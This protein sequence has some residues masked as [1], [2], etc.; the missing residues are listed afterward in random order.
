MRRERRGNPGRILVGVVIHPTP[1]K[2]ARVG[3]RHVDDERSLG[4]VPGVRT[5]LAPAAASAAL[6][7]WTARAVNREIDASYAAVDDERRLVG[8]GCQT[9]RNEHCLCGVAQLV[10]QDRRTE[11][12]VFAGEVDVSNSKGPQ[13]REIDIVVLKHH[14]VV[15]DDGRG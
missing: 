12:R 7:H 6:L 3:P 14:V 4:E 8:C 5:R 15:G 9:S 11:R 10:A 1:D 2:L 13:R